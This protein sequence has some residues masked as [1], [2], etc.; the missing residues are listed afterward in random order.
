MVA[1]SVHAA[2]AKTDGRETST[3]QAVGTRIRHTHMTINASFRCICQFLL[4]LLC[5]VAAAAKE[6]ST[7]ALFTRPGFLH[8]V[9][10]LAPEL[11][12]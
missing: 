2:V 12:A 11:A 10:R 1:A 7:R 9:K 3:A 8:I 6:V 4:S 5:T